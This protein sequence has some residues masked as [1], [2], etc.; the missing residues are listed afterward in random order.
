[1]WCRFGG[2][3]KSSS[4]VD[5]VE[6]APIKTKSILRQILGFDS[7][8]AQPVMREEGSSFAPAVVPRKDNVVDKAGQKIVFQV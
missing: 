5:T 6:R 3:E 8:K 4:C 7:W 1:M 2:R